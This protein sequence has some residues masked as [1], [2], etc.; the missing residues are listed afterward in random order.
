MA[1]TQAMASQGCLPMTVF[2]MPVASLLLRHVL[3]R[4]QFTQLDWV[5]GAFHPAGSQP[6]ADSL[7][8]EPEAQARVRLRQS[9]TRA[10]D[11]HPSDA[12]GPPRAH[13]RGARAPSST[14]ALTAHA[15]SGT[16]RSVARC[17]SPPGGCSAI[18]FRSA[19]V[20][21]RAG[22]STVT[23]F[24]LRGTMICVVAGHP[25][26]RRGPPGSARS[27]RWPQW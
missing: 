1:T 13:G 3:C 22:P 4:A 2:L 19:T 8:G 11:Y 20:P 27:A 16:A 18:K 21:S 5:I 23:E 26:S 7:D 6:E 14:S 12:P 15:G 10:G 24:S 25:G 17:S 9:R